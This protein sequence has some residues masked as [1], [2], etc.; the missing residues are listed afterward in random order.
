MGAWHAYSLPPDDSV[1]YYAGFCG[2]LLMKNSGRWLGK[3]SS[4]LLLT[5][6]NG[7]KLEWLKEKSGI[8]YYP[9]MLEQSHSTTALRANQSLIF[10]D[11]RTAFI[12]NSITNFSKEDQ[13]IRIM[14]R[15]SFFKNM[16]TVTRNNNQVIV[17]LEDGSFFVI[18]LPDEQFDLAKDSSGFIISLK[19]EFS[20]R[21]DETVKLN[22]AE[23]Y[24]FNQNERNAWKDKLDGY[25]EAPDPVMVANTQRWNGYLSKVFENGNAYLDT[26]GYKQL[27]V[28]CVQTLISNWRSPAGALKHNGLFPSAAYQ[29]F[30]GFWSWDSWK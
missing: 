9:G 18:T 28:K 17:S 25:L 22:L 6:E 14:L 4:Q 30:Y 20:L 3:M 13:K 29:G 16:S 10:A 19:K 27:A 15:S 24:F 12:S 5:G 7:V 8:H 2:P 21:P 1:Q 26:A 23:S 11:E